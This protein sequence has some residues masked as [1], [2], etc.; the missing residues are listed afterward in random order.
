LKPGE[1]VSA[2]GIIA[3]RMA[4]GDT[5]YSV[6]VMVDRQRV[7]RV[8]G[9]ETEGV[10]LT[11]AREFIAR[12]RTDARE[13]R[14]NLPRRRKAPLIFARAAD[15]YVE[16]LGHEGGKNIPHKRQKL[17]DY[18]KPYFGS[19]RL[20]AITNFTVG[21]YKKTR[22]KGRAATATINRELAVLNHLYSKA[23]EWKWITAK[24]FKV[25]LFEEGPGRI[26]VLSNDECGRL[27]KAATEDQDHLTWLF[28]MFG[29]NTC[30]RHMEILTAR[31]E[32]VDVERRRL[33]IPNAKAGARHQPITRPLVEVIEKERQIIGASE[34]WIFPSRKHDGH[35][36][37]MKIQFRRIA[38]RAGLDAKQITPHV[39]RHTGITRLVQ[40]GVD[41]ET[42]RRISG[43]KTLSMVLKYTHV[44]DAHVDAAIDKIAIDLPSVEAEPVAPLRRR[45]RDD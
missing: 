39:M 17:R 1:K 13:G 10:T 16:K 19:K 38:L 25:R 41:L 14:L 20:D 40:S 33:F 9:L 31:F 18:L 28:V 21:S 34:G 8:I 5:R 11:Q 42:V 23:V 2:G 15:E 44:S 6:N 29:L 30:M 36:Y 4:N 45:Q 35:R 37:S 27:L 22:Q 12:A 43:H 24:P 26:I 32:N 7:H 3:E